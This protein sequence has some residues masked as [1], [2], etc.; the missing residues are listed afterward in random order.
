MGV[1][2]W[3]GFHCNV[4]E[5][6]IR[7]MADALLSTGLARVGFEY[8]NID[9]C[10]QVMRSPDGRIGVDPA[11]FPGGI[12][13]LA[14]YIHGLGLKFGVYSAASELT[15]QRRPG[16]YMHEEIDVESYC[17]W[18]VDYLKIDSCKG[19]HYP[20]ANTSWIKLRAAIDSCSQ[21]RG[22]PMVLS[23]E[24]C[25]EPDGCG[26]WISGLANLWRTSGDIQGT[27]A[28][29]M[30]NVGLNSKMARWAGP[31]GGPL[32]GGHWNDADI[33]QVGNI[34]LSIT[35]QY[36]HYAL[37]VMMASP[38]LIG[39][40]LSML[41][42]ESLKILGN[43]E[44]NAVNQDALGIQGMPIGTDL[45]PTTASCWSKPLSD[46][47]VAALLLNVGDVA[48]NITCA[49]ADLGLPATTVAARDL[50]AGQDLAF[51]T[52]A[53]AELPAHG[54]KLLKLTGATSL[55]V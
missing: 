34:G 22:F 5:R 8:V 50:W 42:E 48:A 40:D 30:L 43:A 16:T 11:R 17:D 20:Q 23:V 15:C 35:E 55:F 47:S 32:G 49:L 36:S 3:N 14:D 53:I 37:W 2:S 33:L 24:Y 31:T 4:D 41:S 19:E 46:G 38:L 44:V 28:S 13:P 54:C 39:T 52:K 25:D 7:A 1:N 9:D 12:R 45:D 10:W 51:T 21:R 18:G 27:F 6:K 26:T 29:V